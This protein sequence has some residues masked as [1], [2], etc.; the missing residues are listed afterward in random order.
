MHHNFPLKLDYLRCLFRL[1]RCNL[2]NPQI[3]WSHHV[4]ALSTLRICRPFT[5][6]LRRPSN[7]AYTVDELIYQ[8]ELTKAKLIITSSAVME[9]ASAAARKVG[10]GPDRIVLLTPEASQHCTIDSLVKEG[11]AQKHQ[12]RERILA[13]G[14]AKT[15]LAILSFS[16]GTTGKPKAVAIPHYAV[17]ANIIQMAAH[18]QGRMR[19][20]DVVGAG[21]RY[22]SMNILSFIS[23][24][25]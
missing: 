22:Q 14:E 15:K 19:P 11:L 8:L 18:Q 3:R 16:S 1:P 6:R 24:T 9:I 23:I 17:I 5:F 10:L 7:P 21:T 4:L 2:G 12:F 25:P 13:P 20:G